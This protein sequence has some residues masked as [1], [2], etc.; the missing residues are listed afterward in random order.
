MLMSRLY[1]G[2]D[3]PSVDA[4]YDSPKII[5]P[6]LDLTDYKEKVIGWHPFRHGQGY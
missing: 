5:R 6:A 2:D 1:V 4:R 3:Q